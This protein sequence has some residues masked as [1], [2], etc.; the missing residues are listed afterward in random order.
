ML[1]AQLRDDLDLP[2]FRSWATVCVRY[3]YM[4]LAIVCT[5]SS[6]LGIVQA[7]GY[8]PI[9]QWVGNPGLFYNTV[10]QGTILALM[11]VALVAH[12]LPSFIPAL[13]P[14]LYLAHSRAGWIALAFGLVAY[15]LRKPLVLVALAWAVC[16]LYTWAPNSSDIERLL[17]W[18]VAIE[19]LTFWGNGSSSF[20]QLHIADHLD[21]GYAHNDYLQTVFEYGVWSVVPFI[22]VGWIALQREDQDWPTLMTFLFLAAFSMPIHMPLAAIL[23][24]LALVSILIRRL[25]N[26]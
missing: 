23:G 22:V 8:H 14:G 4:I 2:T 26:A 25:I 9:A 5:T 10:A 24:A 15:L 19:H 18:R 21:P 16:M 1:L 7:L 6:L 12:N 20:D 3:V 11:I 17:I 13:L